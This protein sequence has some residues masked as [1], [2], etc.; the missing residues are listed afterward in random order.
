MK[1]GG[2][3]V[4]VAK[5]KNPQ[6]VMKLGNMIDDEFIKL[7]CL[8]PSKK[9]AGKFLFRPHNRYDLFGYFCEIFLCAFLVDSWVFIEF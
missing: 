6:M 5:N 2:A 4:K 9:S 3:H 7:W 1:I 8:V